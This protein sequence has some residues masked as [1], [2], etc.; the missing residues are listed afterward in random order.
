MKKIFIT[1]NLLIFSSALISQSL[2]L[3]G[4]TVVS[5]SIDDFG[6]ES[7]IIVKNISNGPKSQINFKNDLFTI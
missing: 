2:V 7:H 1:L 3:T 4:S 6:I 5:G